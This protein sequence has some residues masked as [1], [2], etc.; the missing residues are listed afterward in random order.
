M[1]R[2]FLLVLFIILFGGCSPKK[3]AANNTKIENTDG[4]EVFLQF[5]HEDTIQS[6]AFSPDGD[7]LVSGS[8]DGYYKLWDVN[9]GRLLRTFKGGL[10]NNH[11]AMF[12]ND[13]RYILTRLND[14]TS[15]R[16]LDPFTGESVLDNYDDVLD[17][18]NNAR[19]YHYGTSGYS[20][21]SSPDGKQILS[22]SY[23]KVTLTDD[24][25]WETVTF[26]GRTERE[27]YAVFSPDSRL[28]AS[29]SDYGDIKIWDAFSGRQT[30]VFCG[31]SHYVTNAS[32][33]PDGRYVVYGEFDKVF[34]MWD[35]KKGEQIRTFSAGM[36]IVLYA[37]FSPDGKKIFSRDG[38]GSN[39]IRLWDAQ[40]GNIIKEYNDWRGWGGFVV[41]KDGMVF[42]NLADYNGLSLFNLETGEVFLKLPY[43]N[44]RALYAMSFSP[45]GKQLLTGS[46]Y[47]GVSLWDVSTAELLQRFPERLDVYTAV[48]DSKGKRAL[49]G[50]IAN[51]V[52]LWDA[53][54]GNLIRTYDDIWSIKKAAFSPDD[55]LIVSSS[56]KNIIKIFETK[57]GKELRNLPGHEGDITSLSFSPDGKQ[58]LSSSADQTVRLWDVSTG[59]E[60]AQLHNMSDGEWVII[61]PDGYYNAS[62][63]GDNYLFVR[64]GGNIYDIYRYRD[65][66]FRPDIVQARLNGRAK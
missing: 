44:E 19:R 7:L 3:E 18:W 24:T 53:S 49:T 46:E 31:H 56:S 37:A 65:K 12:T 64:D 63:N 16:A 58:I 59:R 57:S 13:G 9:T 36:S 42:A 43:R 33:S 32:F 29:G 14:G 21:I 54:K 26:T 15:I 6:L 60:I 8:R 40:T 34:R 51:V 47:D 45:D 22:I 62:A 11:F 52:N 10:N 48:F 50:S 20:D 38:Q 39:T 5:G 35:V 1:P 66:Y 4:V 2:I 25:G 17:L 41:N 61:T 28:V 27:T 30:P 55:K 23:G